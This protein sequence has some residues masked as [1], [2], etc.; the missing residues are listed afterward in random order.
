MDS[1]IPG[2]QSQIFGYW[3]LGERKY[4]F[5]HIQ[6]GKTTGVMEILENN[7]VIGKT[8]YGIYKSAADYEMHLSNMQYRLEFLDDVPVK[9][10][11]TG[12]LPQVAVTVYEKLP[13][14]IRTG[15]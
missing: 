5:G 9:M 3:K 8:E 14:A 12:P 7:Q 10:R 6:D 15:M 4:Y 2:L 1:K 11:L 13:N